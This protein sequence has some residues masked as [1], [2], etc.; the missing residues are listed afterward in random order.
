MS[1]VDASQRQ[2]GAS[3][4]RLE[5]SKRRLCTSIEKLLIL[6]MTSE[7]ALRMCK[8]NADEETCKACLGVK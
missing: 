6:G 5:A 8:A 1:A 3:K 4:R 7:N 2:L